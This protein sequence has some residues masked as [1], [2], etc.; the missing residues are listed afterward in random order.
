[1]RIVL[2]T[3]STIFKD[4]SNIEFNERVYTNENNGEKKK[5]VDKNFELISLLY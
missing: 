3:I 5:Q 1:M 4:L 2:T